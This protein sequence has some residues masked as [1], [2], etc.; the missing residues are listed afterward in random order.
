MGPPDTP[1]KSEV[2]L[3]RAHAGPEHVCGSD[4]PEDQGVPLAPTGTG[5]NLP[6]CS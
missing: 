3:Q 1:G 5:E 2:P 4:R 6:A